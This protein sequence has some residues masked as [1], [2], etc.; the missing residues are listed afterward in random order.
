MPAFLNPPKI[1]LSTT[2]HLR[3]LL[4]PIPSKPSIISFSSTST[5]TPEDISHLIV[6]AHSPS[7]ALQTF[8]WATHFP[9][10]HH[11]QATFKSLIQKLCAFRRFDTVQTVLNQI[12]A[13][14]GGPPD[15]DIFI[16]IIRGMGRARM[17]RQAIQISNLMV[18]QFGKNP[19]TKIFNSVLDVLVRE[20]IDLGREF[21]RKRMMG[22][23]IQGDEY[24]FGILMK[25]LCSTNRIDEGFRLLKLMK[26]QGFAPNPVIYN[27]LIHALCRNGKVGRGRSLVNEMD[28]PN[29][30]T[31]NVLISAYCKEG[32]L[33]RALVMLE[34]CFSCGFVPDVVAITKLVELL[35]N[36]G[37]VMEAAEVLERV[38]RKGGVVD[39]IS[40]NA[41]IKGFCQ[42][43]KVKMGKRVLKEMEGKGCL[44][45]V[46]TYNL[47]IAGFCECG[48]LDEAVDLFREMQMVGI[49]LDYV[50]YDTLIRGL[51]SGGRIADGIR[52]L[53]MMEENGGKMAGR[54]SPYNSIIYG[55]Y[56]ENRLEEAHGFLVKMGRFFPR[57]VDRSSKILGFCRDGKIEE[58]K[59]LYD[60]MVGEGGVPS[61]L[62]HMR[63][64]DGLCEEQDVRGAFELMNDMVVNACFPIV[65]TFNTLIDGFCREGSLGSAASLLEE[66]VG[67]GCLPDIGS[68][69]PLIDG[70]C[71][72]GNLQRAVGLVAEM[73]EKGVV[74]DRFIWNSLL[75][76]L[77]QEG[78]ECKHRLHVNSLLN[79]ICEG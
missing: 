35:C 3:P 45:N 15:D 69:R 47:L 26:S 4:F 71:R 65:V 17:T 27:T 16:T 21:F 59:R 38:E 58:A 76:F 43:G 46:S 39:T 23:G 61:A 51:C 29:A 22:C 55:L 77:N 14:L 33:V 48:K 8:K 37:R 9:N 67:R 54:I 42:L 68:Y 57:A 18:S 1:P 13:S 5:P 10:F 2:F 60:Q 32:D 50:T 30:V 75:L 11:T 62:V 40:Y 19:S 74:P 63:L 36:D 70:F 72:R 6:T 7:Q 53:G 20:D 73:V 34:T 49:S 24:T 64:I 25:G 12:P 56:R 52:I 44:P 78:I 79:W 66:M 28:G 31:F 41:L